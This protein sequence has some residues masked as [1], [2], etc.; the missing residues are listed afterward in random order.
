MCPKGWVIMEQEILF[1]YF[2]GGESEQFS[3]YRIPR[4]LIT[5]EQFRGLSIGPYYQA[6]V[7]HD[8]YGQ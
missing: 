3:Y 7:Q 2:Y 1:D 8:L 5:G 6:A 4:A